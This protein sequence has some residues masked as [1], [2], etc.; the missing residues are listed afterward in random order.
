MHPIIEYFSYMA[1]K[2]IGLIIAIV[3][4]PVILPFVLYGIMFAILNGPED[5]GLTPV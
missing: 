1:R 5:V 4:V 2:N 3:A